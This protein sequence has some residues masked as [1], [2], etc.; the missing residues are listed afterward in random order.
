M[1]SFSKF[2]HA[3]GFWHEFDVDTMRSLCGRHETDSDE[4]KTPGGPHCRACLDAAG[5]PSDDWR[6][7]HAEDEPEPEP[8]VSTVVRT[9]AG[10]ELVVDVA[11]ACRRKYGAC[12]LSQLLPVEIGEAVLEAGGQPLDVER[13]RRIGREFFGTAMRLPAVD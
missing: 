3:T 8:K 13:A 10:L 11:A 1:R 6:R 5:V 12:P 7:R 2:V 4:T 9:D